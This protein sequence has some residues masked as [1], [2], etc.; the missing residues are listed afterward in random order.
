MSDINIHYFFE[1][2]DRFPWTVLGFDYPVYGPSY[3][4]ACKILAPF[5]P[6]DKNF[7]LGKPTLRELCKL[8][9][10]GSQAAADIYKYFSVLENERDPY[11]PTSVAREVLDFLRHNS[12]F[13]K[14]V[15]TLLQRMVNKGH[16]FP[17]EALW[18]GRGSGLY[19]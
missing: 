2:P 5:S 6:I 18:S 17:E 13:K 1:S 9:E 16:E 8:G 10:S 12:D 14:T 7:L 19:V 3:I 15:E 4:Y 11:K